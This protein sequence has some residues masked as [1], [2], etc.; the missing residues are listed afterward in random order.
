ME[1]PDILIYV[2]GSEAPLPVWLE[3]S[4]GSQLG[5]W[6]EQKCVGWVFEGPE[7]R[8]DVFQ[9]LSRQVDLVGYVVYHPW[10]RLGWGYDSEGR[11]DDE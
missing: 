5:V 7:M 3:L 4:S 10:M 9:I 6:I 8:E 1:Q 2:R 11:R